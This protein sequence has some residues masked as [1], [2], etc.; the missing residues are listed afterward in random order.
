MM[1]IAMHDRYAYP[2]TYKSHKKD[3][4]GRVE[5]VEVEA[6]MGYASSGRKPPKGVLNWVAEP[7]P[8]Q[9][10]LQFE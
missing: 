9:Q 7:K 6:D 10:P 4:A 5:C 2:V 3:S 1:R 8:G